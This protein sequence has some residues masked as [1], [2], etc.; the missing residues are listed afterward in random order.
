M[1]KSEVS[2][3]CQNYRRSIFHNVNDTG[4]SEL[5]DSEKKCKNRFEL[6]SREERIELLK[7]GITGKDI[8][9]E[10]LRRNGIVVIGVNWQDRGFE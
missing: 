1:T 2:S 4:K 8:E 5:P 9:S 10:Y 7:A 3:S 6:V